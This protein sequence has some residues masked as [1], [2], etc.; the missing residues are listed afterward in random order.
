MRFLQIKTVIKLIIVCAVISANFLN[1]AMADELSA[2]PS[3]KYAVD[4]SHASIVFKIDHLGFSTYVGRFTEFAADLSLD[5]QN[6]SNS[7]VAVEVKIDSITTN[8]PFPEK[9]DFDK[10]LSE[11]WFKSNEFPNM[12]YVSKSVSPLTDGTAEVQ[13]ELTMI[14]ETLPVTLNIVLNKAAVKHPL[15]RKPTIG[16][17]A[18]T[19]IDRTAWGLKNYAPKLGAEVFIEI[20]GEFVH[21]P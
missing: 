8:Y 3:G 6:F 13:G 14:G 21:Q 2:M 4:P 16:F 10:K 9:E 12:S 20:E 15:S 5:S 17:S 11:Q 7:S 1:L 18:K 19:K